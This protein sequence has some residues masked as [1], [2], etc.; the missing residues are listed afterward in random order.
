VRWPWVESEVRVIRDQMA[1]LQQRYDTLLETVLSRGLMPPVTPQVPVTAPT[2]EKA[3]TPILDAIREES[4]GD[5]R[6]ARHFRHR[7]REL[8]QEGKSDGDILDAIRMWETTE[9]D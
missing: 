7:V 4:D 5:P 6:L 8:R 2:V 9:S 3:N 1:T